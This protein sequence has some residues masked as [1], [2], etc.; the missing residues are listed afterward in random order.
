MIFSL[1]LFAAAC[2]AP[3]HT[4]SGKKV[5]DISIDELDKQIIENYF[6]FSTLYAKSKATVNSKSV[7][8]TVNAIF[9]IQR[10]SFIGISLRMLGIEGA[11]ILIT[12]D[13]VKI[14]DRI[15]QKYYPKDFS[16]I[17]KLFSLKTD[18]STLQNLLLGDVIYYEGTKY[19]LPSDTC[20]CYRMAVLNGAIKNTINIYPAF[21]LM[22][23]FVED[24]ENSRT[25]FL[26]Y[27]DYRKVNG[28]ETKRQDFSFL[29]TIR[30]DAV[31]NYAIDLEFTDVILN[32]PLD[33][34]FSVS[35]KYEKIQE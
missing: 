31:E 25:M 1:L 7:N 24:S 35:S 8:Q 13:S 30:I 21:V 19:P 12:Q 33:F 11:K 26:N 15:N 22:N 5:Q 18:F 6:Q 34:T 29:R 3:K 32:Q 20:N 23:M 2:T 27:S 10:D 4:G 9:S 16:Y 14:L 17:E 28:P